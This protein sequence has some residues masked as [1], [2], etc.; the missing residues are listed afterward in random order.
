MEVLSHSCSASVT[1]SNVVH[2]V[3]PGNEIPLPITVPIVS[4]RN[5][6]QSDTTMTLERYEGLDPN[7]LTSSVT[8]DNINSAPAQLINQDVAS[9]FI[10]A[11]EEPKIISSLPTNTLMIDDNGIVNP[12]TTL[13]TLLQ[14]SSYLQPLFS[15]LSISA[16]PYLPHSHTQSVRPTKNLHYI[17]SI[18]QLVAI[19]NDSLTMEETSSVEG[20]KTD[21]VRSLSPNAFETP[22]V[23]RS[24]NHIAFETSLEGLKTDIVR[25]LSHIAFEKSQNLV[26]YEKPQ[27]ALPQTQI[28][29]S[30]SKK[31]D[32][33]W[34]TSSTVF[35]VLTGTSHGSVKTLSQ[36]EDSTMVPTVPTVPTIRTVPEVFST[37]PDENRLGIDDGSRTGDAMFSH[38]N[39]K[40]CG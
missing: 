21:I 17:S 19:S 33:F 8:N 13:G 9:G 40:H 27:T 7:V 6:H 20:L 35:S 32:R 2:T 11:S 24:L 1:Y 34:S 30:P 38:R 18:T 5:I 22:S 36:D 16:T 26:Y 4:S 29:I 23:V 14:S 3:A 31:L 28:L 25:S 39:V 12:S 10:S 37:L 15:S